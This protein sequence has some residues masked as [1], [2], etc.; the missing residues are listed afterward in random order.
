[1]AGEIK[2]LDFFLDHLKEILYP[3]EWIDLDLELSK[4]QILA[5]LIVDRHGEVIMSEIADYLNI[6]LSTATGIINRLVNKGYLLR[7][8]NESDRRIVSIQLTEAGQAL[9]AGIKVTI[10]E[11]V[12]RIDRLLTEEEREMLMRVFI[13]VIE[14]LNREKEPDIK[15]PETSVKKIEIE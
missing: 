1:M 2:L 6:P 9:V 15:Q 3:E 10:N 11:Y 13:K 5:M 14:A 12:E 4:S 7:E 8:R